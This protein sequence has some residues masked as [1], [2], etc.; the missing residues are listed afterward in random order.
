MQS[1][2]L[3][4]EEEKKA[5]DAKLAQEHRQLETAITQHKA[6][7]DQIQQ[8]TNSLEQMCRDEVAKADQKVAQLQVRGRL[9]KHYLAAHIYTTPMLAVPLKIIPCGPHCALHAIDRQ[10]DRCS[11]RLCS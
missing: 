8:V 2:L 4:L 5:L 1:Q 9:L 7:S 10:Q 11:D 6:M 3:T